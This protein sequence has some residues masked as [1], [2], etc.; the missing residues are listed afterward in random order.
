MGFKRRKSHSNNCLCGMLMAI[1]K[2]ENSSSSC[3]IEF[4][5]RKN[6]HYTKTATGDIKLNFH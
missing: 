4:R 2:L 6:Q 5:N 1:R 3:P